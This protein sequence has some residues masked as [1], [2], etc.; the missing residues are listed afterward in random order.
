VGGNLEGIAFKLDCT[1]VQNNT[2]GTTVTATCPAGYQVTG[3]GCNTTPSS[4]GVPY[5][6]QPSGNGWYCQ[7]SASAVNAYAVCC[8]ILVNQAQ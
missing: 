4:N 2:S 6:S 1:T 5:A 8:R 7:E 3:G